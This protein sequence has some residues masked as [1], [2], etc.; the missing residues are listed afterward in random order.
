M[1]QQRIRKL[2]T[3][4]CMIDIY[5]YRSLNFKQYSFRSEMVRY[6]GEIIKPGTHALSGRLLIR[7]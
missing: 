3:C 4:V 6:L 2:R 5:L 1:Q 7:A